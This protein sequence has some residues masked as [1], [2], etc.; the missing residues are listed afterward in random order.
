MMVKRIFD[1]VF[2]LLGLF[3]LCPLFI[4]VSIAIKID[5]PGPIFFRQVRVGRFGKPFLIHKFRTMCDK[6]EMDGLKITVIG[7]KRITAVGKYLRR[8]KIDEIAQLFD[9][10]RGEMSLVGPRPE[11]PEFVA[12]YPPEVKNAVLS[13][14]PGIT[15]NASIKFRN[16]NCILAGSSDPTEHYINEVLPIKIKYYLDYV[17]VRSFFGDILIIIRTV[18]AVFKL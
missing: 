10:L 2:S 6:S 8:Y 17:E 9:V 14:R 18:G 1:I 13:I 3:M 16:E 15:D 5:S 11:V 7:D 12:A 4:I